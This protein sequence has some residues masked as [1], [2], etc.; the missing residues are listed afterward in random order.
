MVT[1]CPCW[2][3]W[4]KACACAAVSAGMRHGTLQCSSPLI[5]TCNNTGF[6]S[7]AA[8]RDSIEA[9]Y[10]SS[11]ASEQ[12]LICRFFDALASQCPVGVLDSGRTRVHGTLAVWQPVILM[13]LMCVQGFLLPRFPRIA[14]DRLMILDLQVASGRRFR[15][16]SGISMTGGQYRGVSD[17]RPLWITDLPDQ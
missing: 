4:P 17:S 10:R 16:N 11:G 2:T 13:S 6:V 14:V 15:Q 3:S 8:P 9:L 12:Y 5:A 1:L 7:C